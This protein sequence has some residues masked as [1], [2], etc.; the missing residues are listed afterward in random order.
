MSSK[1]TDWRLRGVAGI[2]ALGCLGAVP[3]TE[4]P[5][6]AIPIVEIDAHLRFLSSDL[7]EG[8]APATRGGQLTEEYIASI[9][10]MQGLEPGMP[11]GSYF[12]TVP[13][14]VSK[15]ETESLQMNALVAGASVPLTAQNEVVFWSNSTQ[16][17][18]AVDSEIVFVGYGVRADEYRWNDFKNTDLKG[19]ILLILVNDPPASQSE[20]QLFGGRA[21]TYYGRWTYKFEEAERQGAAGAIIIHSTER[22]GYPWHTVTGSWTGEQRFLGRDPA[23]TPALP[24]RAWLKGETANRLL[25]RAGLKLEDLV[26]RSARRDFEPVKT[27]IRLQ[28]SFKTTIRSLEARNVVAKVPGRDPQLRSETV[29]FTAHHDHIGIGPAVDGDTIYNGANDNASGVANLLAISSAAKRG[30]L[31]KRTF[32]FAAVTAE[33]SGLLGS[34]YFAEHP[35]LPVEKIVANL[36]MDG[37]NLLGRTRDLIVQGETR[38]SLGETLRLIARDQSL[39]TAPDEFPERGYFYRSDQFSLAQKG[40][41]AISIAAGLDFI[42]KPR[43]WGR[44]QAEL[45]TAKRYHQ[46]SDEY[47]SD[48][49]LTGAAQLAKL[50]LSV[51]YA[52]ANA[53]SVPQWK[54]DSEFQRPVIKQTRQ[55]TGKP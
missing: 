35:S 9:F 24:F 46:P 40:V 52:V 51:G 2:L 5:P 30:P 26:Q 45:Y 23:S 8:R 54:P 22:A 13:I 55:V 37:G 42:G 39:K 32:Y 38:S 19:K 34:Q 36:N 50:V 15:L 47:R 21:M 27:G 48:F 43:G 7:L 10:R 12:Q 14:K 3:G 44:E 53:D 20:P 41:P 31:P 16:A 6:V 4:I 33:E 49:D 1:K 25:A 29:L 28:G 11:D 17:E 18:T